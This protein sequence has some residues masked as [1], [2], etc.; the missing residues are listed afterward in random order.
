MPTQAWPILTNL[1]LPGLVIAALV[2]AYWRKDLAL[3]E[4]ERLR[5]E[6]AKAVTKTVMDLADKWSSALEAARTTIASQ[7]P[8]FER[9]ED[10][11]KEVRDRLPNRSPR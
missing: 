7:S 2:F 5:V 4:S 10:L 1:G 11:L 9:L 3:R 6:D 8:V